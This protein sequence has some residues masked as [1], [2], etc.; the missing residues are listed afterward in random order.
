MPAPGILGRAHSHN[1]RHT[2]TSTTRARPSGSADAYRL[3]IKH[4]HL[5]IPFTDMRRFVGGIGNNR[6]YFWKC[7]CHPVIDPHQNHTVMDIPGGNHGLQNK[8]M[9]VAGRVG[10][11][12]QTAACGLPSQT[13]RCPDPLHSGSPYASFPSSAGPASSWRCCPGVSLLG[14]EVR[15]HRQRGFF[16]WASPVCVYLFHQFLGVVLGCGRNLRLHLLFRV[17]VGLDVRAI[18][19]YRLGERYPASATS[20]RINERPGLP[21][22]R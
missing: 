21:S 8:S 22:P 10:L 14:P 2:H 18:Y 17:G 20:S 3:W 1:A 13:S 15:H 5:Q 9:F 7:L 16:P 4:G 12:R 11:Y 6:L 19:E